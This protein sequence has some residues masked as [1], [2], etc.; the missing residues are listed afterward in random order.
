MAK[1]A[2]EGQEEEFLKSED[3]Q[4]QKEV[5]PKKEYQDQEDQKV[6]LQVCWPYTLSGD[7]NQIIKCS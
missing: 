2:V 1:K 6:L 7:E 3:G 5:K 4:G